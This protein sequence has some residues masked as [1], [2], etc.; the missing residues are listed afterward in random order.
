MM[1][2]SSFHGRSSPNTALSPTWG[3]LILVCL[4]IHGADIALYRLGVATRICQIGGSG[5]VGF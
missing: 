2:S 5:Q 4:V 1:Q 3:F